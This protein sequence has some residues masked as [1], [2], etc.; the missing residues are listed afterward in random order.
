MD[1]NAAYAF[2]FV[3][4]ALILFLEG[5]CYAIFFG[6]TLKHRYPLGW[7]SR[8]ITYAVLFGILSY[9]VLV[10]RFFA[11]IIDKQ[12]IIFIMGFGIIL[13]LNIWLYKD[14]VLKRALSVA[15]V[16]MI[17]ISVE[18]I[19]YN[20]ASVFLKS[21]DEAF[22]QVINT[23]L[24]IVSRIIMVFVVVLFRFLW[25]NVF[26]KEEVNRRDFMLMF[27]VVAIVIGSLIPMSMGLVNGVNI[28][29]TE[30]IIGFGL[31][32]IGLIVFALYRSIMAKEAQIKENAL[33]SQHDEF[34]MRSLYAQLDQQQTRDRLAHESRNNLRSLYTLLEDGKYDTAIKQVAA[35]LDETEERTQR[36]HTGVDALDAVLNIKDS[37]ARKEGITVDFQLS[38]F[39]SY[40]LD[41]KDTISVLG[42]ILDNAIEGNASIDA[43]KEKFILVKLFQSDGQYIISVRNT[44]AST[45]PIIDNHIKTTKK[46]KEAHGLGLPI[47]KKAIEKYGGDYELESADGWFQFTAII[48]ISYALPEHN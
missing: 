22:L 3:F 11:P 29:T 1:I 35:L 41:E 30:W 14:T 6:F 31:S 18:F 37:D 17:I 34:M 24:G 10:A 13:A 38:D 46:D 4:G 23:L 40:P 16:M 21:Q 28:G 47:V 48:P 2:R 43:G 32:A 12:P 36:V 5:Y 8:D 25:K 27:I 42:N 39:A 20:T 15:S 45:A 9:I 44:T 26:R 7:K 19:V 33:Q